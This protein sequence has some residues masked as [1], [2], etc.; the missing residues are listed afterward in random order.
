MNCTGLFEYIFIYIPF[1]VPFV[2][3]IRNILSKDAKA[4]LHAIDVGRSV[5][6]NT[7]DMHGTAETVMIC[8]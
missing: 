2:A 3:M 7:R 5:S 4:R 1:D 8:K 6:K